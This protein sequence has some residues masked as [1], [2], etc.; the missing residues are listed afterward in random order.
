MAIGVDFSVYPYFFHRLR[1]LLVIKV[2]G[3][4]TSKAIAG[5]LESQLLFV[6]FE[7]N[8]VELLR[9]FAID[10]VRSLIFLYF[11]FVWSFRT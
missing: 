1:A 9:E 5:L 8:L 2:G 6:E 11:L 3:V 10:I 4:L 7:V